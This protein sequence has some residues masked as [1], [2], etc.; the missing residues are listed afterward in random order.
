M[1]W[2]GVPLLL[3]YAAYSLMYDE[4][5]SWYSFIV[6]TLVG[7]VYAWGF[8]MMVFCM[9]YWLISGS[10]IVHQLP[11]SFRCTHATSRHGLQMYYHSLTITNESLEYHRGRSIQFLHLNAN[12]TSSRVFP[13]RCDFRDLLVPNVHVQSG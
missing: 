13:R 9:V 4:H 8:M 3:A 1:Y 12:V 5:K 11:S 6:T 10:C 2:G 7:F